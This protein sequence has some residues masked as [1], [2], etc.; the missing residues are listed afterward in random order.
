MNIG[1][2]CIVCTRVRLLHIDCLSLKV[3]AARHVALIVPRPLLRLA[4][5]SV[6]QAQS[7]AIVTPS[8]LAR[9]DLLKLVE[10]S[11][12]IAEHHREAA[13]R[14]RSVRLASKDIALEMARFLWLSNPPSIGDVDRVSRCASQA[15][16]TA[17]ARAGRSG[18]Q[19][20]FR[21]HA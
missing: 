7:S 9:E 3:R 11:L 16:V 8:S 13:E 19:G 12:V 21:R 5:L 4:Q 20:C 15:S 14:Q 17:R 2:S 1:P 6:G 18:A 10:W